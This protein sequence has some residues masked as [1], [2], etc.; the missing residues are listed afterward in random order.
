MTTLTTRVRTIPDRLK[1]DD[2][3][4]KRRPRRQRSK[5]SSK[6]AS[7][8]PSSRSLSP[9]GVSRSRSKTP[10]PGLSPSGMSRLRSDQK[11][12]SSGSPSEISERF[13]GSDEDNCLPCLTPYRLI[14]DMK[15]MK[16]KLETVKAEQERTN[17]Q[18]AQLMG[19]VKVNDERLKTLEEKE[20]ASRLELRLE[21]K[22][23]RQAFG[24]AV[25]FIAVAVVLIQANW[26][27]LTHGF[28]DLVSQADPYIETLKSYAASVQDFV[29]LMIASARKIRPQMPFVIK[30]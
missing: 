14:N 6:S 20:N 1:P 19:E 8:R 29:L 2:P 12:L 15:V 25:T 10:S 28:D 23:N 21:S 5:R 30:E 7:K 17:V 13:N 26:T 9:S 3:R 11:T 27:S 18:T 16:V 4:P 22:L 24:L